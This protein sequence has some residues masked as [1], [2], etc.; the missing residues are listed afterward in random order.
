[1]ASIGDGVND[2]PALVHATVGTGA[3]VVFYEGSTLVVVGP[4]LRLL[5]YRAR[6]TRPRLPRRSHHERHRS[7]A[8]LSE[9]PGRHARL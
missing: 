1:M 2:A 5:A 8:R 3:A 7:H 9:V 4:A 6:T